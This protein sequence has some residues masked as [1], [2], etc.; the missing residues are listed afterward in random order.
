MRTAAK[1]AEQ[2]SD[3]LFIRLKLEKD[4]VDE[5]DAVC[6]FVGEH[7]V[8]VHVPRLGVTQRLHMASGP[9][10]RELRG[11]GGCYAP[12]SWDEKKGELQL[13]WIEVGGEGKERKGPEVGE[14]DE[15]G[16]DFEA[17][18]TDG[19]DLEEKGEAFRS[20]SQ[21]SFFASICS[22]QV[23]LQG[24]PEGQGRFGRY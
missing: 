21:P 11:D 24:M 14:G 17:D 20:V 12:A 4:P 2:D 23:H 5:E 8:E 13:A 1:N 16:Q 9:Q 18:E 15:E 7:S 19:G 10:G 3:R 6:V 22:L